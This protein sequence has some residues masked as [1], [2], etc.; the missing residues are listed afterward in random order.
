MESLKSKRLLL[1]EKYNVVTEVESGT[2][3]LTVAEK[4]GGP[5]NTTWLL[6]GSKE[7]LKELSNLE[8][9]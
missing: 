7:K 2:K 4:F 5:G 9:N 1:P 8:Y 6:P 3:P